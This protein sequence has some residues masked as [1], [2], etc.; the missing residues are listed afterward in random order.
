MKL[1]I[2]KYKEADAALRIAQY[3]LSEV[4]ELNEIPSF[5]IG[6]AMHYHPK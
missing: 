5:Q 2:E 3:A 4:S 1:W 6:N